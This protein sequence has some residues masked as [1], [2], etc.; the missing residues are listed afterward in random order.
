MK[1]V[2][3]MLTVITVL[4]AVGGG[5]AFKA[6]KAFNGNLQCTTWVQGLQ[7][8]ICP[9]VTYTTTTVQPLKS[10]CKPLDAPDDEICITKSV[11]FNQ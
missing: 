11:K 4:A 9:I 1:R 2:K 8:T 5:L 6:H 3:I 7:T 10:L